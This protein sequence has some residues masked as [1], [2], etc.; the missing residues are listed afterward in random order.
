M[1]TFTNNDSNN[2]QE[3]N[4]EY[5][6]KAS[7]SIWSRLFYSDGIAKAILLMICLCAFN[8]ISVFTFSLGYW[9]FIEPLGNCPPS[10][11][12]LFAYLVGFVVL[13]VYTIMCYRKG[14]QN[15]LNAITGAFILI[16]IGSFVTSGIFYPIINAA[17]IMLT[18]ATNAVESD[19]VSSD[20]IAYGVNIYILVIYTVF[21][22]FLTKKCNSTKE[23]KYRLTLPK[24][25]AVLSVI[26][27]AFVAVYGFYMAKY[28]Y[29]F[30]DE[31][32]Y[33]ETPQ[34]TYLSVITEEQR[35][36]YSKIKIGD[37]ESAT[38]KL[39]S[40]NG[41]VKQKKNFE[42][43]M[44][45]CLF[46]YS[47]DDYLEGR[48][49]EKSVTNTC[50][51]YSY[52]IGMEEPDTW[53]DVI[54][55]IIVSYDQ[56]GKINYKLFIPITHGCGVDGFYINYKHGEQTRK[57]F[58]NIKNGDN[59]AETLEFIKSTDAFIIEDEEYSGNTKINTYKIVLQC[60]YN[61]Q[62]TITDFLFN[63]NPDNVA[64]FYDFEITSTDGTITKK[65]DYYE[66]N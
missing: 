4:K 49:P 47:I 55:C 43:Y 56:N 9:Y 13:F 52:S 19:I 34:E 59:C 12:D 28:G 48:N 37:D 42:D 27:A 26:C 45:D 21:S 44:W 35:N 65:E 1:F 50:A 23:K 30:F 15:Q 16:T 54:S 5:E 14:M 3:Q 63:H 62:P 22:C 32:Y 2:I 25:T 11:V 61:L 10:I 53:D 64:Y 41:F 7:K 51:I 24:I 39:L 40:E 36:I 38:E 6:R 18:L 46:P 29:E 58:D 60:S 31:D 8:L 20:E 57:W 17:A 33:M 66:V